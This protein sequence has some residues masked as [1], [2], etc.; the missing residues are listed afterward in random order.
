M[1]PL[2]ITIFLVCLAWFMPA[3]AS[4]QVSAPQPAESIATLHI[5]LN[6]GRLNLRDVLAKLADGL[7]IKP[8]GM[9]DKFD[10]SSD[11]QSL[12]GRLQFRLFERLA[13]GSISSEV[14]DDRITVKVN[15]Q[16]LQALLAQT[17]RTLDDWL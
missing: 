2:L 14:E 15:R 6:H 12:V 8:G 13:G 3:T 5:P 11:V 4:A 1:R 10:W 17:N 9:F 7:G 16:A